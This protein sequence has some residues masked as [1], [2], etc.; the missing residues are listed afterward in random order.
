MC[1]PSGSTISQTDLHAS[2]VSPVVVQTLNL[3][4]FTC[5]AWLVGLVTG[6][7]FGFMTM[8]CIAG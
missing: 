4:A 7:G 3:S 6:F 5:C 8:A 1:I 2:P